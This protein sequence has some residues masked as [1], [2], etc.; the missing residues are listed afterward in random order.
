MPYLVTANTTAKGPG[1]LGADIA[2]ISE[3]QRWIDDGIIGY[4]QAHPDVFTVSD[5]ATDPVRYAVEHPGTPA[6]AYIDFNNTAEAGMAVTIDGVVYL[7]ADTAVPANGVWTNGA[8][9]AN[10]ATSLIAAINGDTRAPVPFTAVADVSGAGVWLFWDE[11]G[12]AGNITISESSAAN[13]TVQNSTGGT[14]AGKRNVVNIKH[15]VTTQELLSGAVEIPLPFAPAGYNIN[16]FSA[17]GAPIY[18][19]NLVT[20]QTAPDRIRLTT[21]GATALANTNVVHLTAWS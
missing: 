16:A 10:S 18:F 12:E 4:Y 3:Q 9:A 20:V 14:D 2:W 6:A 1:N 17:T 19:T 15:T 13:C 5:Q 8:S 11:V 21:N 7:E